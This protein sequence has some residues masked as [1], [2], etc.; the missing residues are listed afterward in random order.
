MHKYEMT[1]TYSLRCELCLKNPLTIVNNPHKNIN[2]YCALLSLK[3][4]KFAIEIEVEA[5]GIIY[6]LHAIHKNKIY[7]KKRIKMLEIIKR[8][9]S[10]L[11]KV[12]QECSE[13]LQILD[14]EITSEQDNSEFEEVFR[15]AHHLELSELQRQVYDEI[16]NCERVIRDCKE[17]NVEINRKLNY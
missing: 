17:K 13:D 2:K 5:S 16:N 11:I 14:D 10:D 6:V 3:C 9:N 7:M 8:F 15:I 4:I 1:H 12:A